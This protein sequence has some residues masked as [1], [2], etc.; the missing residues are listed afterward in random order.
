MSIRRVALL[1]AL[2]LALGC[3]WA[4]TVGATPDWA[5]A[6]TVALPANA[7]PGI[8]EIGYQTGGIAT[9]AYLEVPSLKPLST[10]LHI[11]A[12]SP[13]GG[14]VDQLVL[15]STESAIPTNVQLAVAPDGAAVATW[16]EITGPELETS[17]LRYRA[18]YRPA[19]SSTWEA[20]FTIATDTE[21]P[22]EVNS[23][24]SPA[25]GPNGTATVGVQHI[26]SG[27]TGGFQ[28]QFNYRLD[29]AVHPAGGT[30]STQRISPTDQSAEA[31]SLGIDG[32][33]NVTAAYTLRFSEGGT[34][35][36]ED[37]R[38]TVIAQRLSATSGTWGPMED[39]TG[40]EITWTADA[41]HV[42]VNE[43]GDAVLA[44]QYVFEGKPNNLDAWAVTRQGPHG[45]WTT[46][47]QLV[48]KSPS[49][50][51]EGVGMAPDGKGYVLY[52][53]QGN[54]S[55][56]SCEGVVRAPA[57]GAFSEDRCVS[58][59]GED[60]FSGSV[61][62]IGN[63]AYFAW[64]G[65]VPGE[66][67][68]TVVQG[69]RWL[70]SSSLPDVPVNLEPPGLLYGFPTLRYDGQESVVAFF[71]DPLNRIRA[72]AFDGGPPIL[73]GAS[74]PQTA[75]VNQSVSFAASFVDLWSGLGAGQPTWN[76]GD[77]AP[78]ASGGSA[79]HTYTKPGVYNVTLSAADAFENATSSSYQITVLPSASGG[80]GP[81]VDSQPPKV[82]LSKPSCPKRLSKSACRRRRQSHSAWQTL[83]GTVSDSAPSSGIG[84][85]KV[86]IY[87]V[88]GRH[89]FGLGSGHFRKTTLSKA[90]KTFASATLGGGRWTLRLPKLAPGSYTIVVR[91]SDRA[92]HTTTIKLAVTLR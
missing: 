14:Y 76:F 60:T 77:G 46:P 9:E 80:P 85:V 36:T 29:V 92:G 32:A 86:A 44:Y 51:P 50:A 83:S 15:A 6:T 84:G 4:P 79:A 21:R 58:P 16:S 7:Y 8:F 53:F 12:Q 19:G 10:V 2:V 87:R 82:T 34:N 66:S 1:L 31:L 63:D 5:P 52:S 90:R 45:A 24:L 41:L 57:G 33:G 23:N 59:K 89:V 42:A 62:F 48:T 71:T 25:I 37:D 55:G 35:K 54:S 91:A 81:I 73:L 43:A 11:G 22:K 67:S 38:Y 18:A 40:S 56:E 20:P 64:R 70:D 61:A 17:P 47:A 65:N 26:A 75:N 74:V 28:K 49:S 88:Q 78:P 30:W 72:A 13:G 69:A 3:A 27:E 68:N 39:I